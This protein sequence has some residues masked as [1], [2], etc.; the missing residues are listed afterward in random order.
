ML[1]LSF[2]GQKRL[3]V[4][5]LIVFSSMVQSITIVL[6][7]AAKLIKNIVFCLFSLF[8]IEKAEPV[9]ENN[10]QLLS[11]LSP[12]SKRHCPFLFDVSVS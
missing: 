9:R 12:I 10:S 3:G 4:D 7:V 1:N 5:P 8:L 11:G 2:V 6:L